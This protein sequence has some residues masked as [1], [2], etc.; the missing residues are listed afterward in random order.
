[1]GVADGVGAGLVAG[2]AVVGTRLGCGDA[3][4]RGVAVRCGVAVTVGDGAG[5][6]VRRG[7]GLGVGEGAGAGELLCCPA[8]GLS[9]L[10]DGGLTIR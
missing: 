2:G 10:G 1:M 8:A 4:R 6:A 9:L 7:A 5:C 3:V